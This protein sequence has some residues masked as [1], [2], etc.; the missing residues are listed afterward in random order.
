MAIFA[1]SV[2]SFVMGCA[3]SKVPPLLTTAGPNPPLTPATHALDAK[4][5]DALAPLDLGLIA[6]L[7]RGD[8]ALIRTESLLKLTKLP[9][10]QQ[11]E[12]S[13]SGALMPPAEAAAL[14]RSGKRE[15]G[16]LTYGWGFGG[17]PDPDGA[18]LRSVQA[19]LRTPPCAHIKALF[20]DF[21]SLYQHPPGGK[22]TADEDAAFVRIPPRATH[23]S[24]PRALRRPP[25]C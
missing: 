1:T 6:A 22:R 4:T 7:E 5:F 20:W 18:Y 23:S 13:N 8:I 15:A 12:A 14:I 19:A 21:A 3:G 24:R 11:L 17:D 10:R 2:H 16:S 25:A 9:Y